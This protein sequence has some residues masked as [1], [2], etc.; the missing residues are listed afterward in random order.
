MNDRQKT[1]LTIGLALLL[2][3][4]LFPPYDYKSYASS[5]VD[6]LFGGR[7]LPEVSFFFILSGPSHGR[8]TI[9]AGVWVAEFIVIGLATGLVTMLLGTKKTWVQ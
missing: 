3:A 5:A 6:E 8:G 9:N 4:V 2:I 7:S 1:I